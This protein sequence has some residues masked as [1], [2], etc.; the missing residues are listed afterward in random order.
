VIDQYS[1]FGG[2]RDDLPRTSRVNEDIIHIPLH[3][4][5]ADDVDHVIKKVKEWDSN[6]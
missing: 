1:V 4:N 5:L 2:I 3:P 6:I